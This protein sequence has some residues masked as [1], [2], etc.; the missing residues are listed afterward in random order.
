M[1]SFSLPLSVGGTAENTGSTNLNLFQLF[2][3]GV[4]ILAKIVPSRKTS[5]FA[6]FYPFLL[7]YF[8]FLKYVCVKMTQ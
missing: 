2:L 6:R 4:Y 7:D 5:K 1:F 3:N 8:I